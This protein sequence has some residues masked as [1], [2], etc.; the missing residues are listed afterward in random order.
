MI[1]H[2]SL[3]STHK[4]YTLV[5]GLGTIVLLCLYATDRSVFLDEANLIRNIV[6]RDFSAL[7]GPL[8]YEQSAP[9]L[10]TWLVK[11]SAYMGYSSL[12]FRSVPLILVVSSIWL[13]RSLLLR[14][15]LRYGGIVLLAYMCS[16]ELVLQYGTECKQY[17]GDLFATVLLLYMALRIEPEPRQKNILVWAIAGVVLQLLSMPAILVLAAIGCYW[18]AKYGQSRAHWLPVISIGGSWLLAFAINYLLILGPGMDSEHMQAF[19]Q[20]Y[21]F[22]PTSSAAVDQALAVVRLL[23]K[24]TSVGIASAIFLLALG[25]AQVYRLRRPLLIVLLLPFALTYGLSALGMYSLIER[26]MLF[27]LPIV[28]LLAAYGLDYVMYSTHRYIA[29]VLTPV[30]VVG[31]LVAIS[32]RQGLKWFATHPYE[33]LRSTLLALPKTV[34]SPIYLSKHGVATYH[35]Y[36]QIECLYPPVPYVAGTLDV[37]IPSEVDQHLTRYSPSWTILSHVS[38]LEQVSDL[39][40]TEHTLL[41]SAE[42]QGSKALLLKN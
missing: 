31:L 5:A 6:E 26:L 14:L 10:H 34:E 20:P 27:L 4:V 39:L 13:M 25:I 18:V 28:L 2:Q 37:G 22:D 16:H 7:V 40:R 38:D 3:P 30:L 12:I 21:F 23:A 11:I 1:D 19:H 33:D 42:S 17:G 15:Q 24:K 29:R 36:T 9:F 32:H 41:Q 8:G 35:Y